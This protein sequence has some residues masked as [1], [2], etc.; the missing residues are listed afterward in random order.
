MYESLGKHNTVYSD[1]RD[2][3]T[4]VLEFKRYCWKRVTISNL[5]AS[6][7]NAEK[8][9]EYCVNRDFDSYGSSLKGELFIINCTQGLVF[10]IYDDRG[11]DIAA[12]TKEPLETLYHSQ[13]HLLLSH[14][15]QKMD[16]LFK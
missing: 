16:R 11:L 9:I 10:Y 2:I 6:D 5:L 3:Y 12:D 8:T 13:N 15:R 1:H 4:D 7:L 14:D